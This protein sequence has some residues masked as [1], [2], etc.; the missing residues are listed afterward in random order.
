MLKSY[1][2][3]TYRGAGP[4]VVR[5]TRDPLLQKPRATATSPRLCILPTPGIS[6]NPAAEC[7]A[8]AT[9]T[10]L[11]S[12]FGKKKRFSS[13]KTA[14]S[15]NGELMPQVPRPPPCT[16]RY[17]VLSRPP[18]GK[19]LKETFS[20]LAGQNEARHHTNSHTRHCLLHAQICTVRLRGCRHWRRSLFFYRQHPA[21]I[22][23]INIEVLVKCLLVWLP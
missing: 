19:A 7:A 18:S 11:V 13:L 21:S 22:A 9:A 5:S 3:L 20:C 16:L 14:A 6:E 17:H 23:Q 15:E 12:I 1:K 4:R 8:I 10:S 2:W